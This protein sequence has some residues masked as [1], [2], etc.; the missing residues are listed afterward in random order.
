MTPQI[1]N[2][3]I[4]VAIGAVLVLIYIFFFGQSSEPAATLVSSTPGEMAS[5]ATVSDQ[6]SEVGRKFLTLLLSVKSI[7]LNDAIFSDKAF[8]SLRDSSITISQDTPE[9]RPNPFAPFGVDI[10]SA[11]I[12]TG[13][14]EAAMGTDTDTGAATGTGTTGADATTGTTGTGAATGAGTAGAGT[15]AGATGTT[16]TGA[17]AGTGTTGATGTGVAGTSI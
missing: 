11:S 14:E 12:T 6:N 16:G 13:A 7:K 8:A 9:G 3:I 10:V 15:A 17:A 2:I 4:F 5:D 1:K